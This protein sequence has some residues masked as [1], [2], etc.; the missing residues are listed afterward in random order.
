MLTA[1]FACLAGVVI[2]VTAIVVVVARAISPIGQG[3]LSFEDT[4]AGSPAAAPAYAELQRLELQYALA[5]ELGGLDPGSLETLRQE[6]D[7]ARIHFESVVVQSSSGEPELS[8]ELSPQQQLDAEA[9]VTDCLSPRPAIRP[10]H[11]V[12][13]AFL[14]DSGGKQ[15]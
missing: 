14:A 5:E 13:A 4:L 6:V 12:A 2:I 7:A 10:A 8:R 9:A 11:A 15:K 3:E 1:I